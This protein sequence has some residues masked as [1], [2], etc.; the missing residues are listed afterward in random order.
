MH[1]IN[2]KVVDAVCSKRQKE[3]KEMEQISDRAKDHIRR[4]GERAQLLNADD[5]LWVDSDEDVSCSDDHRDR[6]DDRISA[7]IKDLTLPRYPLDQ[8]CT[9]VLNAAVEIS[10]LLPSPVFTRNWLSHRWLRMLLTL[11]KTLWMPL[12]RAG[13]VRVG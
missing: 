9:I 6:K 4:T 10:F 3:W 12:W 2:G 1:R 8:V 11:E 7:E 13:R 5:S